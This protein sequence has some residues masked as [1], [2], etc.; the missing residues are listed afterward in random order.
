MLELIKPGLGGSAQDPLRYADRL[1][2]EDRAAP[3]RAFQAGA[4]PVFLFSLKAGGTGLNLTAANTVIHYDT[5]VEPA[6]EARQPTAPTAL[7]RTEAGA[8][9]TS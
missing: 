2:E 5:S 7:V 4:A 9:S 1:H 6:V 8:P 3:V